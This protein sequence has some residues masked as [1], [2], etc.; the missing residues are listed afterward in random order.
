MIAISRRDTHQIF[1]AFHHLLLSWPLKPT[2]P[3]AQLEAWFNL[4]FSKRSCWFAPTRF[5][6]CKEWSQGHASPVTTTRERALTLG[7]LSNCTL[8]AWAWMN[9]FCLWEACF[10]QWKCRVIIHHADISLKLYHSNQIKLTKFCQTSSLG[11][12][13]KSDVLLFLYISLLNVLAFPLILS[14]LSISLVIVFRQG[15]QRT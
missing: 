12:C 2:T 3:W 1:A 7:H 6:Q 10:K 8:W 11:A 4:S 5:Q 14:F 15:K 13:N 9:C